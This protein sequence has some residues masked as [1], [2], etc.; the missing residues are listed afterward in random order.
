MLKDVD[1][2]RKNLLST[3]PDKAYNWMDNSS[4]KNRLR[5]LAEKQYKTSGYEKAMAVIDRMD[6]SEL[7]HY[8]SELISDNLMVGME[9]LKN[10]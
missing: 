5:S 7:R 9:I 2:I 10:E 6:A 8:M 4:V 1:F 3:I